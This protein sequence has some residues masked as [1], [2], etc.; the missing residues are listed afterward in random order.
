MLSSRHKSL[1]ESLL[2]VLNTFIAFLLVF[3]KFASIPVWLQPVGRPHPLVLHFPIVLIL[4][5]MLLEFFR[6]RREFTA[7]PLYQAFVR[8]LLLAGALLA[9]VTVIMGLFLSKEAGY[10]GGTL[11]WHKWTGASISFFAWTIYHFRDFA[12]YT[13][14]VAQGAALLTTGLLI[15][16][17]HYGATLTHGENFVLAPVLKNSVGHVALTQARVYED[18][19]QPVFE[20]C[21]GCHNADKE[22]G[23]LILTDME[24]IL[25][26]GKS[27]PLLVPGNPAISLL[28][29]RIHLPEADR[30]HMPPTGKPQLTDTEEKLLY[31]WIRDRAEYKKKVVDLAPGD[32]LRLLATSLLQPAAETEAYDFASADEKVIAKLRS[33]YRIIYPIAAGVPAL[34]VNIYYRAGYSPKMIAEL[35][36]IKDQVVALDLS[37]M[38]VHDAELQTIA[39]FSNLRSLNLNFSDITGRTLNQLSGLKHLQSLSLAGTP[40]GAEGVK[41]IQ[42]GFKSLREVALW[43]SALSTG[44][45]ARLKT[46]RPEVRLLDG[47][48]DDGRLLKLTAPQL[49]TPSAVF[50]DSF[51]LA[52]FNPIK[53]TEIRYTTDGTVPDSVHSAVYQPGLKFGGDITI[54]SRAFKKG[55]AGSDTT[56]FSF[57]KSAFHPDSVW[58]EQTPRQSFTADGAQTLV[59]RE[60]GNGNVNI[61]WLGYK[62][63]DFDMVCM[64]KKPARVSKVSLHTIEFPEL[65]FVNPSVMEV[66]GGTSL[67][68]LAL[69]G[70]VKPDSARK[71]K[72]PVFLEITCNFKPH[73]VNYLKITAKTDYTMAP[74]PEPPKPKV[75]A[76]AGVTAVTGVA[77]KDDKLKKA[78][79]VSK[80]SD[81]KNGGLTAKTGA[82]AD[83]KKEPK[84]VMIK[85]KGSILF[86]EVFI[87]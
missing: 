74:K 25:K 46:S 17:S 28:L 79:G 56:S 19:V 35:S 51:T 26:G 39:Q 59:D 64:F 24:S 10:S 3:G 12:W 8:F 4:L 40:L 75:A 83:P 58:L 22:K 67:A 72:A 66:W 30:K 57:F 53:G 45:L 65:L 1:A 32:S 21:T 18:L 63:T 37:K 16:A 49:K 78:E 11:Q 77:G 61:N 81:P 15:F 50:A 34:A 36:A 42:S 62:N 14:K 69:L 38:P 13:Q 29:E 73:A 84:P 44:D 54:R 41:N 6:F 85:T 80:V 47:F 87:N 71:K 70:R 20:K 86:D 27:G 60:L 7:E 76:V 52:L 55:W 23:Q 2:F 33:N 31:L 9:A 48:K 5:G 68:R 82:V 43:N